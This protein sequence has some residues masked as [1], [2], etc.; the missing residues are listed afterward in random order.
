MMPTRTARFE[1]F[2]IVYESS[3]RTPSA[4]CSGGV[5]SMRSVESPAARASR[6]RWSAIA[7]AAPRTIGERYEDGTPG[8]HAS[9]NAIAASVQRK[10]GVSHAG[11]PDV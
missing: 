8:E 9:S 6:R 2:S 4:K 7:S 5:R 10:R 11:E 3:A 1:R